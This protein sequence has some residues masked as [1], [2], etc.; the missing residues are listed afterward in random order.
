[1]KRPELPL[2]AART[3]P[4][5]RIPEPQRRPSIFLPLLMSV[6]V[7]LGVAAV[8][9]WQAGFMPQ[10]ASFLQNQP[11]W[12]SLAF[13]QD[14][15]PDEKQAA[16]PVQTASAPQNEPKPASQPTPVP[17]PATAPA[18]P[19]TDSPP[20]DSIA[21]AVPPPDALPGENKPAKPD[22]PSPLGASVKPD[23]DS[24]PAAVRESASAKPVRA[25][26]PRDARPVLKSA[27]PRLQDV[28]VSTNPPGAKAVLD[29]DLE[30]S[31]RTPCM[32]HTTTGLHHLTIAQAGYENEYREIRVGD[33]AQDIPPITL[34]KP[35]GTLMLT[36]N[37]PGATVRVDGHLLQQVTPAQIDL[38]PG[39]YSITVERAGKTQTQRVEVGRSLVFIS[40]PLGQ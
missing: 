25:P 11:F 5:P 31:C 23:Q 1:V 36:T 3:L 12:Q 9:V 29:D 19:V 39:S 37:P 40:I 28:W 18:A 26:A 2:P 17:D 8:I 14:R 22:K 16:P 24:E 21:Q 13:W 7:V 20:A 15:Q 10:V 32:V 38:P 33:T 27:A 6:I 30:Q 4:E 35:C 34:R